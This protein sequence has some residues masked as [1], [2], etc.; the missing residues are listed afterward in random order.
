MEAPRSWQA[1]PGPCQHKR[2]HILHGNTL[3]DDFFEENTID[4]TDKYE[5]VWPH[6]AAG[7]IYLITSEH[8]SLSFSY[9]RRAGWSVNKF[10]SHSILAKKKKRRN[11][12]RRKVSRLHNG[13]VPNNDQVDKRLA[14]AAAASAVVSTFS[15][16]L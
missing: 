12:R 8:R 6:S 3:D 9:M 5:Q 2:Q 16:P 15:S 14:L 1:R 13:D 7:E 10:F 11:L 4:R